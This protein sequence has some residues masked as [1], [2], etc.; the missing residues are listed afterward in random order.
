MR[1][2]YS[3]VD[4]LAN[5]MAVRNCSTEKYNRREV[6]QTYIS[7]LMIEICS[8]RF[9]AFH[10]GFILIPQ[11]MGRNR[12]STCLHPNNAVWFT[13]APGHE[14]QFWTFPSFFQAFRTTVSL[15]FPEY[16]F[17]LSFFITCSTFLGKLRTTPLPPSLPFSYS[18]K[19]IWKFCFSHSQIVVKVIWENLSMEELWNDNPSLCDIGITC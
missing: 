2:G 6:R 16:R 9:H 12:K 5:P 19:W 8:F 3:K 1:K 18:I 10:L 13:R 17:F 7:P 15:R 11:Q 14:S 4:A